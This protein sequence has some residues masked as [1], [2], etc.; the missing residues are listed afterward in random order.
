MAKAISEND[1]V[2][3]SA[4][5]V[6]PD[7]NIR[8]SDL[9]HPT[10]SFLTKVF[11]LYL[12]GFGFRI[13]APF[14]LEN[15]SNDPSREKRVFLCKLCRQVEK[16][17]RFTSPNKTYTYADI[18]EPSAKKTRTTLEHI[19]NYMA[20]YR[21]FKK[22]ILAPVEEKIKQR[23]SLM[24]EIEQKRLILEQRKEKAASVVT[25]IERA[26]RDIEKLRN[27][28]PKSEEELQRQKKLFKEQKEQ[29][30]R[31][32]KRHEDLLAQVKH[33]E[34]KVVRNSIVQDVQKEIEATERS[35]ESYQKELA[36]QKQVF[37]TQRDEIASNEQIIKELDE[38]R[39]ILPIPLLDK[40]KEH[41]KH[42]KRLE[43]ELF[44]LESQN[45]TSLNNLAA[46]Q[47][48]LQQSREEYKR[49]KNLHEEQE[50][51][52]LHQIKATKSEI[53]DLKTSVK[54][55]EEKL[56]NLQV[57]IK[58]EESTGDLMQENVRRI[59]GQYWQSKIIRE[60]K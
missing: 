57:K 45:K 44:A 21:I 25:D 1:N 31:Q 30:H 10:E 18:I 12:K 58:D 60:R 39:E 6:L 19:F 46:T 29:L 11:I 47:H 34:Q 5:A 17:L 42:K 27:E 49:C 24:G 4:A 9:Q 8:P 32:E 52:R 20:Y 43:K 3:L 28:L 14:N 13:E 7:L 56:A 15:A 36:V 37:Q 53:E 16:I 38:L 54:Q 35:I 51:Q 2:L 41:V 26:Q 55:M 23:E 48:Q 50:R 22:D 33:S 40:H 59:L